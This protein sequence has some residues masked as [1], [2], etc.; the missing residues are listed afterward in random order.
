MT[1]MVFA[2]LTRDPDAI[3]PYAAA[4]APLGLTCVA[5]P[6]TRYAPPADPGAL[7]RA[8]ADGEHAAIVVASVRAADELVRAMAARSAA[9]GAGGGPPIARA[10]AEVWA[11]GPATERALAAAG[12][13]AVVP[14]GA[15][16]GA[17]LA[18]ALVAARELRGKR[19]LMPR[20]EDGRT[21][22]RD[23]L[24]A[25]GA[26][27]VDVIAYRTL[28]V[29]AGDPSV[30]TGVE[31]L[32]TQR[33]AV[34]VVFAPSQVA[35]LAALAGPLG[36]VSTRWCTIGDTTAAALRQA[37]VAEVAVAPSPT[38]EGIAHAVGSVYPPR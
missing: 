37:G 4:L 2:V 15:R 11:I 34:C 3:A 22:A 6:V 10:V 12:I 25:A 20:A 16:D 28:A 30:R 26:E 35:A 17:G 18:R 23:L 27:V 29:P 19:V 5:M 36:A 21:E 7:A 33:A 13:R 32:R 9:E 8:A 14:A 24:R 1:E 38:P 31:L